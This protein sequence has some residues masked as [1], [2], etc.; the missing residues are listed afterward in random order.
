MLNR[1]EMEGCGRYK[2]K[3]P[4]TK[5]LFLENVLKFPRALVYEHKKSIFNYRIFD[6]HLSFLLIRQSFIA[7]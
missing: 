6:F 2:Q 3:Q 1:A 4:G 7:L 5:A